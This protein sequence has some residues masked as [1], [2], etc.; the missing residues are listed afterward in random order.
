MDCIVKAIS[1]EEVFR[2]F[3][4]DHPIEPG[5]SNQYAR[6]LLGKADRQFGGVWAE[7]SP[8]QKDICEIILPPHYHKAEGGKIEL[9]PVSGLTV[10]AAIEKIRGIKGY[11][12]TNV[13]CWRSITRWMERY[14]SPIF[15]S[16][17]P[18]KSCSDHQYLTDYN[19]HLIHLDG[20]HRLIAWGLAGRLEPGAYDKGERVI[21]YVAGKP[22]VDQRL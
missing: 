6:E 7:T 16:V 20:L 19:G 14:P 4:R 13:C 9:I 15:L 18:V 22:S 11:E 1:G 8:C 5:N 2:V 3:D 21:A 17:A 10:S 12:F